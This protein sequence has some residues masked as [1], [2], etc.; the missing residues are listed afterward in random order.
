MTTTKKIEGVREFSPEVQKLYDEWNAAQNVKRK[1]EWDAAQSE[2]F[3][4]SDVS[5]QYVP[6]QAAFEKLV[7][8]Y[9]NMG[10]HD[11]WK[12]R[13]DELMAEGKTFDEASKAASCEW[14][15]AEDVNPVDLMSMA[16]G[17]DFGT[18]LAEIE[19]YCETSK[20]LETEYKNWTPSE[21]SIR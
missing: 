5:S 14:A 16:A 7:K 19:K 4:K 1:I 15:A 6:D 2:H 9:S 8:K 3:P 13:H 17:G 18:E 10:I 21:I 11:Q 20:A 12:F